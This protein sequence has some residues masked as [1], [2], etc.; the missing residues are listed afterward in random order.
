MLP[1]G[2]IV[3]G[4]EFTQA[5]GALAEGI[6]ALDPDTGATDSD[7]SAGVRRPNSDR[8][9]VVRDFDVR[10]NRLYAV[11]NFGQAYGGGGAPLSVDKAVRF[12]TSTGLLDRNW[13]PRLAGATAY[14]VAVSSDGRRVHLGGEFSSANGGRG[15]S[16]LA[17][18]N[19][20]NGAL[21]RGW[22]HGSHAPFFPVWPVGGVVL[23]LAVYRNS[24]YAVGAEHF[25]ER[26]DSRTGRKIHYQR[27][28][29]DAQTVEVFGTRVIV[30][31][32]CY[33]RDPAHQIW[34]I[35]AQ[36]GRT[37]PGRTGALRSGD[38]TWA[39]AMAPDGCTWL[40][41]D[42]MEATAVVGLGRGSFWVGRLARICPPGVQ[43]PTE[44]SPQPGRSTHRG[45]RRRADQP[46]GALR[47]VSLQS[48]RMITGRNLWE[49]IEARAAESGDAQMAVDEDGRT[50]TFAE[51]RDWCERA[52]AGFQALGL[53]DGDVV[54]WQLPT[55][56]ESMVLVGALARLGV[57]QNPIIPIY[58]EREVGFVTEQAGSKLLVVPSVFRGFDY[59]AMADTV[60]GAVERAC[61]VL[62]VDKDL[63]E[64]DPSTLPPAPTGADD[65]AD[66]PVRWLFYTSGTTADPK[67]AKHTD[68]SIAAIAEGMGDPATGSRPRTGA[69]WSSR[70]PTSA[71]SP[72]CSAAC[73]SAA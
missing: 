69:R 55:W 4:G 15:T 31:C 71:A 17:T 48:R 16:Q 7:F 58:R 40:G 21:V 20:R 60:A 52:A 35:N 57:T 33:H 49:L 9:A 66:L 14:A 50:L 30:G 34:E 25:W 29:N 11:G 56:F 54:S 6:V 64:G 2:S 59:E 13:H 70:S 1:S 3:V 12:F 41:G 24:L 26:R 44:S 18:V 63:P 36:T 22:D 45:G 19:A 5:N 8:Q 68:A 67:G 47:G 28:T 62:V 65:P 73:S 42:F 43:A 51:Y 23:D 38:G 32:H 46:R 72:G 10:G 39:S 61:D 37:M 27:I 53:S